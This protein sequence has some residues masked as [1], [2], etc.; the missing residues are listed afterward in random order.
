M[1]IFCASINKGK[2][3]RNLCKQSSR[4]QQLFYN[5]KK[6]TSL[7]TEF[8]KFSALCEI[9]ITSEPDKIFKLLKECSLGCIMDF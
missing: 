9:Q 6:F 8:A 4:I 2:D 5:T 1:F 7:L 3:P